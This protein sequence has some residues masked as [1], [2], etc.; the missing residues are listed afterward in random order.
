[1]LL[2]KST[3]IRVLSISLKVTSNLFR[4]Q[5]WLKQQLKIIYSLAEVPIIRQ[6]AKRDYDKEQ[7]VRNCLVQ[8]VLYKVLKMTKI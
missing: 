1:M 4:Q 2:T 3:D 8:K 7:D 5:H 6:L